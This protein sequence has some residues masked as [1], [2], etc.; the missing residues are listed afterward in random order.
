MPKISFIT[1]NYVARQLKYPGGRTEDWNTHDEATVRNVDAASFGQM[2]RDIADAGFDC[3]DIWM[4]HCHF[5]RHNRED[6]LELVKG[7][8]SQY[9]FTITSY[10]GGLNPDQFPD[11]EAPFKFMKQLGAPILA[12]GM[13]GGDPVALGPK[14]NDICGR[15]GVKWALENHPE[16]TPG[17]I[18]AK[19][20]GGKF[21]NIGVALD[22]GWCG[23][24]GMDAVEAARQL[25]EKLLIVHLKDVVKAGEHETCAL[26]EGIVP[27]EG[28]V[29]YL[30][31][32][33]WD[34]TFSIE[35]EPFDRDPMPEVKTSLQRVKQWL[36]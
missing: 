30:V 32:S 11:L 18:L 3:I 12:G 2:A 34:G 6:Y 24:H 16:K 4:A 23:T 9:D 19:I 14:I 31:E 36:R 27:V 7:I 1:A 22:T 26:G 35:H 13:W 33:G 20:G 15:L 21:E 17:E 5:A 28:V 10:A 29:R 25:R 8:C